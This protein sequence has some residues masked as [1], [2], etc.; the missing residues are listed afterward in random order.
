MREKIKRQLKRNNGIPYLDD[1]ISCT[2]VESDHFQNT[3]YG[4][5]TV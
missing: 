3:M 5:T 4:N 1:A 2:A